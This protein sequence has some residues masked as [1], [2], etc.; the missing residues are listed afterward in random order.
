MP[1]QNTISVI[2]ICFN[3][4][5]DVINTCQSVDMQTQKP[6]HQ[7]AF[8]PRTHRQ[9]VETTLHIAH[10][11]ASAPAHKIPVAAGPVV[12]VLLSDGIIAGLGAVVLP[13]GGDG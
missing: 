11:G 13:A 9:R 10:D 6:F 3:N 8:K 12:Q 4:L 1:E 2:T 7:G 5:Q